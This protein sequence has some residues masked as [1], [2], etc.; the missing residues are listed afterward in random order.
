MTI[1]LAYNVAMLPIAPLLPL[2]VH[3][4]DPLADVA[5]LV[6]DWQSVEKTKTPDGKEVEFTLTGENR[7]ILEGRYLQIDEQFE[8]PD[9]GKLANH[10]LITRDPRAGKLRAWWFSSRGAQPTAMVGERSGN[11]MTLTTESGRMRIVYD[12]QSNDRYAAK[13]EMRRGDEWEVQTTALYTR[14]KK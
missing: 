12:I 7:V 13:V 6:G 2:F 14:R 9:V 5:F 8:L 1:P 10:I 11:T 4:Q 3:F